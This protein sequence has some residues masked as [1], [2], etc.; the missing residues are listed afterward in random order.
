M[1]ESENSVVFIGCLIR[2]RIDA[3]YVVL[4]STIVD[5]RVLA[6]AGVCDCLRRI[7][8]SQVNPLRSPIRA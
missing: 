1:V 8:V 2:L 5:E 4:I 7:I 6:Y 3:V